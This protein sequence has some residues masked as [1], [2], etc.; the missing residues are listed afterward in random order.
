MFYDLADSTKLSQQLAPEVLR[1]VIC[2]DQ[3]TAS[4]VTRQFGGH[5]AEHLGDGLLISFGWPVAHEDDAQRAL[6]AG[7]GIVEAMTMT[8]TPRLEQE[9]GEELTVRIG[10][11]HG[12][13]TQC[14]S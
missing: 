9:K 6:H 12:D 5:M 10:I 1:Q 2:A 14:R 3:A 7:M 13:P 8:L 11:A 4:E